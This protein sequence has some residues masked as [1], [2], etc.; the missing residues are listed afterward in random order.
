[1]LAAP[2]VITAS[3]PSVVTN[4]EVFTVTLRISGYTDTTEIDGYNFRI[5]YDSSVFTFVTATFDVGDAAG[6]DQQWLS[7]ANQEASPDYTLDSGGNSGTTPGVIIISMFDGV[8]A[9]DPERGTLSADGFL[10]SFNL[11]ATDVGVG[12]ITPMA[13]PDGS[14][15]FDTDLN[16]TPV[17]PVFA[18]FPVTVVPEPGP[19]LIIAAGLFALFALRRWR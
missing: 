17:D 18:G 15:F 10:V 2:G 8:F 4:G 6:V 13:F 3:G 7:K 16:E 9:P 1:M 14:V 19:I 5:S 11:M 12:V